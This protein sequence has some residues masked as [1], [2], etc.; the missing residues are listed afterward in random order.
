M[1]KKLVC[2]NAL[3]LGTA[4]VLVAQENYFIHKG[5]VNTMGT[6]TPSF[7]TSQEVRNI[8]LHGELE[9]FGA[10]KISIK[11]ETDFFVSST[12]EKKPFEFNHA[13]FT[14]IAFHF[15]LAKAP[16]LDPYWAIEPGIAYVKSNR[17]NSK[18]IS[19]PTLASLDPLLSTAIGVN[20]YAKKL[21]YFS[22]S[23]RYVYGQHLANDARGVTEKPISL[24]E[25]K[26]MFG[27]GLHFN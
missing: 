19:I 24:S 12:S 2:I 1:V 20:Y 6:F 21:I 17:S 5:L 7:M 8:Y 10:D 15:P 11:G 3:L 27:L 14:G 9:Y 16:Y 26:C 4:I 22:C 13:S 25:V 23:L 18:D